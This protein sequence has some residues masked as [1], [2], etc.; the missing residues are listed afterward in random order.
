MNA[1]TK[2][3]VSSTMRDKDLT[4]NNSRILTGDVSRE[5]ARLKEQPGEDILLYGS[6]QL[7]NTLLDHGLV[8]DFRLWIF[9]LVRGRGGRLFPDGNALNK[10]K[11]V[12]AKTFQTGVAILCY[13]P[14]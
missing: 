10:L 11:L 2:H 1:I 13:E 6:N 14:A 8:N 4:W 12:D 9:P 7:F 5:V 3:V